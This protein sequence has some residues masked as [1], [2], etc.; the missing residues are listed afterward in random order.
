MGCSYEARALGV[1]KHTTPSAV[2]ADF[3]AV[4]FVHAFTVGDKCVGPFCDHTRS[5]ATELSVH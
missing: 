4:R 3:P 5:C 1:T 2:R